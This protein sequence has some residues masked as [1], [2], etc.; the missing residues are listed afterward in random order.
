MNGEAR[1]PLSPAAERRLDEHLALL[2]PA[3]TE[4][5]GRGLVRRVVRAARV[6][7]IVR[8]PLRVAGMIAAAV[9]DGLAGLLDGTRRR[10]RSR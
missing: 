7:Q 3:D 8:A 4:P 9:L 2:R 6:Q 10:R 1:P 5:G